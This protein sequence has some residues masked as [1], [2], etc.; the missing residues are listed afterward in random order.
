MPGHAHRDTSSRSEKYNSEK[1]NPETTS[2][3]LR[4]ATL[5]KTPFLSTTANITCWNCWGQG[6]HAGQCLEPK[7]S[8]EERENPQIQKDVRA[9]VAYQRRRE[10]HQQAKIAESAANLLKEE[11]DEF[12]GILGMRLDS[13][14]DSVDDIRPPTIAL[15]ATLPATFPVASPVAF[16]IAFLV[17]STLS[18]RRNPDTIYPAPGERNRPRGRAKDFNMWTWVEDTIVVMTAKQMCEKSLCILTGAY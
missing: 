14:V 13:E 10:E 11:D 2:T 4:N 1:Y 8:E 16:P 18:A 17:A 9:P 3:T 6:H 5:R 12:Q 7:R 15:P